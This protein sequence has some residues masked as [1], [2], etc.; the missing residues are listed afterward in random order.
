MNRGPARNTRTVDRRFS[1]KL[2]G[3]Q[4]APADWLVKLA[5]LCDREGLAGAEKRI[6]YS[7]SAISTVISGR[8]AGD[9][10]RVEAMVRGALMAETVECPVLGD[11]GRDRCLSEQKEPFRATSAYRARL[12]H[13]CRGSCPFSTLKCNSQVQSH[14]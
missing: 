11:I 10:V 1:E 14:D 12:Y 6:G 3:L 2:L 8:Y 7:R 13:A 9:L 4:P 5:S